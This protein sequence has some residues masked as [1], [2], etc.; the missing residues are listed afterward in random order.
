MWYV[1]LISANIRYT[2]QRKYTSDNSV[3]VK[4]L[5]RELALIVATVILHVKP[6][7]A[8]FC[9]IVYRTCPKQTLSFVYTI[10]GI[11]VEPESMSTILS[12]TLNEF[13]LNICLSELRHA[14][15][16][17]A[18]KMGKAT[19][20]DPIL[21]T[22]ANHSIETSARYGRDQDSIVGIPANISEENAERCFS[23]YV[24]KVIY[25]N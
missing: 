9:K 17:F 4:Y 15:D 23:W 19:S 5:P 8:E 16:A 20:W 7:E 18:H 21:T 22:T 24:L 2:K 25:I 14:L 12:R 6:V 3:V 10:K 11:P 13:G 1:N